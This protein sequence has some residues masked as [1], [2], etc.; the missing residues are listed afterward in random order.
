MKQQENNILEMVTNYVQ[1]KEKVMTNTETL[2][3]HPSQTISHTITDADNTTCSIA[4]VCGIDSEVDKQDVGRKAPVGKD[5][6]VNPKPIEI[7]GDNV[8]VT[9]T[10]AKMTLEKQRKSLHWF[11]TMAK[12]KRL[13][14]ADDLNLPTSKSTEKCDILQLPTYSWLPTEEQL[15]SLC[16]NIT[17]HVSHILLKYIE[18]LKTVGRS[19]P[20]Y[21]PHP[22]LEK[23]KEKSV[24]LNCDLIEASENSSQGMIYEFI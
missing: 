18:F 15:D 7:L 2:S 5:N 4:G 11:L 17:F 3:Q 1:H 9:I 16:K 14:A 8:D 22:Y 13:T 21:I 23:T 19:F 20:T 24:F 12:Q 10:P 6:D